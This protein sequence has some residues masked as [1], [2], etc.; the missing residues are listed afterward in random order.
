MGKI[1]TIGV[2][3]SGGDAPGM[4]AAVRAVVRTA[5]YNDLKVF[6]I[7]NG[8]D[9]IIENSMDEFD[10][11][12]VSNILQKGGTILGSAR[13][14][15]FRTVE[16]RQQAFDNLKSRKVDALVVIG[17]DGTFN[18][19][20]VFS[21]EH[22]IPCVGIPGTIDNDIFGT[23]YTIGYDTA[24]NTVVDAVDKIKDT[25]SSHGR[26]FFVEVMGRD[27]GELALVSG[28]SCGAESVL[29]PERKTDIKRLVN[30]VVKHHERHRSGIIL[31]AEGNKEGGAYKISELV[32]K[33]LPD[34]DVRVSV[35]GH[36][37]RGG[38]P[39]ATDR[40]MASKLGAGAVEA[41]LD[42]QKSI[43]IGISNNNVVHV[44]FLK[45]TKQNKPLDE[46]LFDLNDILNVYK[47]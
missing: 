38:T 39:T 28:L 42:D 5:I 17:G 13:S 14:K 19:A 45:V 43:M 2:L 40:L 21:Q 22:D 31:V 34:F 23:D 12:N 8:Y 18:G 1:K 33:E 32:Q 10:L 29:V 27:S 7:K 36:M 47:G 44:P 20:T 46:S 11:S 30:K 16:G 24:L 6:G 4:N 35:L 3:T 25:A 41:L 15:A 26:L 9:G 37:Q